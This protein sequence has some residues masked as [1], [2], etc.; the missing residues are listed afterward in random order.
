[1]AEYIAVLDE[2]IAIM[3]SEHV[4]AR[5]FR[6]GIQ[7]IHDIIHNK[8]YVADHILGETSRED[9]ERTYQEIIMNC[10]YAIAYHRGM[11]AGQENSD[12][13]FEQMDTNAVLADIDALM[14]TSPPV[15]VTAP[16]EAPPQPP[17]QQPRPTMR[18]GEKIPMKNEYTDN[19]DAKMRELEA[20]M[21]PQ[22]TVSKNLR[23]PR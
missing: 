18:F 20:K 3:K 7:S 5:Q 16:T 15:Q 21:G 13:S 1:M 10:A 12:I 14:E 9:L 11:L 23:R 17:P 2:C 22:K 19:T 4:D 6:R 8:I